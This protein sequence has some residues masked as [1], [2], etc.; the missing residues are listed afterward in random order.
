M[1][2]CSICNGVY[3]DSFGWCVKCKKH[4]LVNHNETPGNS[5]PASPMPAK[6]TVTRINMS[7]T[8][9]D[10]RN[11]II[12]FLG[13]LMLGCVVYYVPYLA[14]LTAGINGSPQAGIALYKI[15]SILC[16]IGG[17]IVL[18]YV[19]YFLWQVVVA[20]Y[21]IRKELFLLIAPLLGIGI[22]LILLF[23]YPIPTLLLLILV[24]ILSKKNM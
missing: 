16:T 21:E 11:A 23:T 9:K 15:I 19:V 14:K 1:K 22:I 13:L 3:D 7:K 18:A 4:S 20:L 12:A 17:L 5:I 2:K 6:M 8:S 24:A 10:S